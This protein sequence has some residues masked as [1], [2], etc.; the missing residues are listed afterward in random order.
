ML[1]ECYLSVCFT[2]CK[3][4]SNIKYNG[5]VVDPSHN[6]LSKKDLK[7][8]N[9][10][11]LLQHLIDKANKN[12][13][14]GIMPNIPSD[15]Y[16]HVSCPGI[17]KS[18]LDLVHRSYSHFL[19]SKT[20][21]EDTPAMAFGRALHDAV[22]EPETFTDRYTQEPTGINKRTKAGREEYEIFLKENSGK[23]ILSNTDQTTIMTMTKKLRE[24]KIFEM[25]LKDARIEHSI[26]WEDPGTGITCKCRPDIFIEK[27][28]VV[29]DLKTSVDAS[30][31]SFRKAIVNYSYDKQGAFYLDGVS[32]ITE[33][34]FKD[35]ILVVIEKKPPH[36]IAIY[37]LVEPVIDAGRQ[38]YKQDLQKYKEALENEKD[39]GYPLEIQPID[40]ATFG[41]DLD[42]R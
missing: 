5:P 22:L 10:E 19:Y 4:L 34:T 30:F 1:P 38:L 35:F 41:F 32:A 11:Q 7:K 26:F 12:Q 8:M 21:P 17:S 16:H 37:N 15:V 24:H 42:A 2:T 29:V 9:E 6:E 23:T 36:G 25:M 18:G 27:E 14:N 20:H 28:G 13:L 39:R 33:Q 40:M 31:H 3:A